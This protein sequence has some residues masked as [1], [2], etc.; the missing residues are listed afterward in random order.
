MNKKDF[1]YNMAHFLRD[2]QMTAQ[3]RCE[4]SISGLSN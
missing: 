3:K 2:M 4:I 1:T